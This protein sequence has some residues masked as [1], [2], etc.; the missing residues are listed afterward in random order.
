[1]PFFG[2]LH[3]IAKGFRSTSSAPHKPWKI[4]IQKI[5]DT[6]CSTIGCGWS[7]TFVKCTCK[8]TW[9][10]CRVCSWNTDTWFLVKHSVFN[11]LHKFLTTVRPPDDFSKYACKL[12]CMMLNILYN[13]FINLFLH[14]L[15][16]NNHTWHVNDFP[17]SVYQY[18]S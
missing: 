13:W 12:C 5:R 1:M 7:N 17:H 3:Y 18:R 16:C 14:Y 8:Y 15:P 2:H 4:S 11:Q 6:L 9:K 10:L